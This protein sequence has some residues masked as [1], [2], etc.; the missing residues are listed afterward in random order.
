MQQQPLAGNGRG[1]P[2]GPMPLPSQVL[3]PAPKADQ[4]A[5]W[6]NLGGQ[7]QALEGLQS[8][9]DRP[10]Y[11][12]GT[13]VLRPTQPRM[14]FSSNEDYQDFNS[15]AIAQRS[16]RNLDR[17]RGCSCGNGSMI[18]PFAHH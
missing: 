18:S 14:D 10:S 6:A 9:T 2:V 15:S 13:A 16:K 12:Q 17:F 3:N 4:W 5:R 1:Y 11:E 7:Q 8:P